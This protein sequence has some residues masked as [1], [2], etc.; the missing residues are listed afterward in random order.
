MTE[1]MWAPSYLGAIQP[2]ALKISIF[3]ANASQSGGALLFF[4]PGTSTAT[5]Q[6]D[7]GGAHSWTFQ[8]QNGSTLKPGDPGSTTL[9][10]SSA[11]PPPAFHFSLAARAI[12]P[13]T[14]QEEPVQVVVTLN[15]SPLTAIGA[16]PQGRS[17]QDTVV[18]MPGKSIDLFLEA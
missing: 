1:K 11:G 10:P 6:P 4:G 9:F 3:G 15:G 16:D 5:I 13:V 8:V 2:G 17:V 7:P 12:N 14:G 18:E